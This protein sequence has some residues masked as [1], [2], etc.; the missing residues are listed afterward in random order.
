MDK[1]MQELKE[2]IIKC[3]GQYASD[4]IDAVECVARQVEKLSDA[5]EDLAKAVQ[6]AIILK[7]REP[8]WAKRREQATK[9]KLIMLD[10][11]SKIHRCRNNC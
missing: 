1:Q 6:T 5:F 7:R 3:W 4:I 10:K 2:T 8:K 11:R 9:I